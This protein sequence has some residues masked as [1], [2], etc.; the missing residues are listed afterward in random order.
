MKLSDLFADGVVAPLG[1]SP[2]SASIKPVHIANGLCRAT[3]GAAYDPALLNRLVNRWAPGRAEERHS[4]AD[5][6]A[7]HAVRLG[8][9][10]RPE[11]R[12]R[13][14]AFRELLRDVIGAD[15]AVFD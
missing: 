13:L 4:S 10:A 7:D 8:D 3:L 6:A 2:T 12:E 5:L 9:L 1:Y 15:D 11:N 14:N